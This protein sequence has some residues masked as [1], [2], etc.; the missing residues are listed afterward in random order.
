M[1]HILLPCKDPKM[2]LAASRPYWHTG[3]VNGCI[4]IVSSAS[5][6]KCQA[7]D[8]VLK[9]PW[10][11][12]PSACQW[13]W[14]LQF[15]FARLCKRNVLPLRRT[16]RSWQQLCVPPIA[17]PLHL[18]WPCSSPTAHWTLLA[19][20]EGAQLCSSTVLFSSFF[21]LCQAGHGAKHKLRTIDKEIPGVCKY[22]SELYPY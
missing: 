10:R 12:L 2:L 14:G 9:L 18:R 8:L 6:A 11:T 7:V 21:N 15:F 20:S 16:G 1:L 19:R 17:S 22:P 13:L 4:F 5:C 3:V